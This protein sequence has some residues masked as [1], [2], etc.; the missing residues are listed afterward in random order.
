ML[1]ET[2]LAM[3]ALAAAVPAIV[4]SAAER[5]QQTERGVVA[6]RVHRVFDVHAGPYK[7]HD[8]LEF[9]GVYE[10]G[11][12]VKV[13]IISQQVGGKDADD[14]TKAQTAAKYENPAPTD[15]FRR[16]YD[17]RFLADY[18]YEVADARTVRFKALVRDAAHGDG[19][20]TVDPAGNVLHVQYAPAALP[21]Y[22]KSGT[23]EDQRAEVLPGYWATPRETQQYSGRYAIFG[24]GAN[25]V[26]TE[27]AFQRFDALP[28]ALAALNEGH[29]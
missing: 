23:V 12:L 27:S 7:R 14:R 6:Y 11:R 3:I 9:A 4:M 24:G 17:P 29:L 25:V 18:T 21:Q 1:Q 16:P 8:D 13:R 20:F 26:I 22:S 15:V 28:A 2:N 19:T 10:N 5:T